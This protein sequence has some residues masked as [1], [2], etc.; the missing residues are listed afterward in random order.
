MARVGG[1]L[2][3]ALVS[4]ADGGLY[5]GL[6]CRLEIGAGVGVGLAVFAEGWPC[7]SLV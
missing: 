1:M 2:C 5:A 6:V 4:F 7:S 3:T